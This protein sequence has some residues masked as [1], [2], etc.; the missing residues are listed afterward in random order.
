MTAITGAELNDILARDAQNLIV[1]DSQGRAPEL[2]TKSAAVDVKAAPAVTADA[3]EAVALQN[4]SQ[5]APD[6]S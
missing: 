4:I 3:T 5:P 6:V 2:S 1:Q